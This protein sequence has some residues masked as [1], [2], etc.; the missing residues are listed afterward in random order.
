[1]AQLTKNFKDVEF[2]CT[3]CGKLNIDYRLVDRLQILRELIGSDIIV[4]SGYRCNAYNKKIGGYS[5]SLHMQGI[6]ADIKTWDKSKLGE[7]KRL[8]KLVFYNQGVGIYSNHVHVD[9]GPFLRFD[10][11]Y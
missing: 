2:E 8:S 9:I 4:T 5:K 6:A 1:M 3:C 7:L 11:K 10:G